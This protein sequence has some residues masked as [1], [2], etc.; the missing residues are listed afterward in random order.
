MGQD[1]DILPFFG[2]PVGDQWEEPAE[3]P[4]DFDDD[5]PLDPDFDYQEY[6]EMTGRV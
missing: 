3:I 6:L 1:D 4:L 2:D 5:S